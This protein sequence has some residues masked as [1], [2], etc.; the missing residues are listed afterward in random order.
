LAETIVERAKERRAR[1]PGVWKR[2]A[3]TPRTKDGPPNGT[4]YV[5][6][7]PKSFTSGPEE[8]CVFKGP[9]H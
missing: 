5:V 3:T 6:T 7:D 9:F 1:I 2:G 8:I 4:G